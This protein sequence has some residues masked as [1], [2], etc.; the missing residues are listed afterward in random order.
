MLP[1]FCML[2]GGALRRGTSW[3]TARRTACHL[4]QRDLIIANIA[5]KYTQSNSVAYARGGQAIGIGAG[6]QSRVDCVK[7]AGRK[8]AVWFLRQHPRVLALQFKAGV[9][10]QE[11]VNARVRY[12]EGDFTP[13]EKVKWDQLFDQAPAL[14]QQ[15]S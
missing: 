7:L 14:A 8:A 13:L 4:V 5:L 6:Q 2:W 11:R 12:I 9:K 3:R 15:P 10:R 1:R